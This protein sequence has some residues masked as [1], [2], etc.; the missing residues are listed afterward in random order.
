MQLTLKSKGTRLCL[1]ST[2]DGFEQ[3]AELAARAAQRNGIT[4]SPSTQENLRALGI[5]ANG[6]QGRAAAPSAANRVDCR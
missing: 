2:L 6:S 3:I 1:E 5:S 4:M